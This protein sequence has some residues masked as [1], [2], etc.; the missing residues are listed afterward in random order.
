MDVITFVYLL[1]FKKKLCSFWDF[2]VDR[3]I[4]FVKGQGLNYIKFKMK[5][6]K[7]NLPSQHE[8]KGTLCRIL[9]AIR[10]RVWHHPVTH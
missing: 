1:E 4:K 10:I 2:F 8:I 9:V 7:R 5:T 3:N 6:S